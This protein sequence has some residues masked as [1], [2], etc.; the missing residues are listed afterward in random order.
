MAELVTVFSASARPGMAQLKALRA[1]GYR[2]RAVSRRD[3]PD[4]AG[5]ER[6]SAD[7]DD[8]DSLVAACI[9]SDH[10]LFTSPT[11]SDRAKSPERAG[12]LGWAAKRAG[13]KRLVFNTTSWHPEEITGVPTMDEVYLRVRALRDSGVPLTVVRPSLFM[14]NL[15]TQWVKPE[16]LAEGVL[17]YPHREDLQVSWICLDDVARVMIATLADPAFAGQTIDVGGPETLT[18][19]QVCAMLSDQLGRPIRYERISPREFG[20]RLYTL[21]RDVLGSG[22]ETYVSDMEQHYLFKNATNPFN[23]PM[24]AMQAR[25]GLRMTPMRDWL[26]QQDWSDAKALVGSVSG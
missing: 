1:A 20:E 16:L 24:E 11:F 23:V 18:P 25:L 15:L 14:D 9:G 5:C 12:A 21:F 8:R 10:V 3:H 22:A 6:V 4:F 13:V 7:L 17:R 26:A 2:V 19:P